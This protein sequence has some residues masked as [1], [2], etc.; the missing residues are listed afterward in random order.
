[1][2]H[3]KPI[4]P[5]QLARD[6]PWYTL[7]TRT[8]PPS[9]DQEIVRF[10][11]CKCGV[12]AWNLKALTEPPRCLTCRK[13]KSTIVRVNLDSPHGTDRPFPEALPH[14]WDPVQ[15]VG[16]T[17]RTLCRNCS[18]SFDYYTRTQETE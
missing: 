3:P 16:K 4:S 14:K 17:L 2:S 10:W 18:M 12:T 15:C 7:D 9:S 6:A 13:C 11:S 5:R 1:M 8:H